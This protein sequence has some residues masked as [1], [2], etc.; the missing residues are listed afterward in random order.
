EEKAGTIVA[1]NPENVEFSAGVLGGI[2]G[3][4]F[5]GPILAAVLAVAA[6]YGSKR[7]NEA[8]DA[9]RAIAKTA[10]ESFNFLSGVNSK[11]DV[12]G[13]AGDSLDNVVSKIKASD[14]SD[15]V[16]KVTDTLTDLKSKVVEISDEYD[17]VAKAK[18]ALG[19]A[20]ELADTAIDKSLELEKEYSV[21]E[22]VK[23]K[24]Q[25]AIDGAQDA[26]KKV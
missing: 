1:V 25:K 12:A 26:A 23:E 20:G 7:E 8:G 10:I 5:G 21:T 17:L 11:Y 14:D 9:V 2:A 15:T 18:Q 6:N 22:K 24:V 13:K 16:S 19:V 3:L 4:F